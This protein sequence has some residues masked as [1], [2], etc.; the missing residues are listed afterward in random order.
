MKHQTTTTRLHIILIGAL[1]LTV[2]CGCKK[3]PPAAQGPLPVNVTAVEESEVQDWVAF[4]G[5]VR[6]VESVE[7]RPRVSGYT[8]E[9]KF[10]AGTVVKKGDLLFV[11]DPRPYQAEFD[12]QVLQSRSAVLIASWAPWSKPCHVIDPVLLELAQNCAGKVEVVKVNADDNPNLSLCF[13]VQHIPTLLYLKAGKLCGHL[14]GTASQ[15]AIVNLLSVD[16]EAGG[17]NVSQSEE[18]TI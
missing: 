6:P 10:T 7:I 4:T 15:D 16:S 8:T 11:I 13:G 9:V 1:L 14:L 3:A 17:G 2:F 18:G 12:S 5:R